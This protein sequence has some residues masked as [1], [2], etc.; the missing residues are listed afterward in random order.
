MIQ[1]ELRHYRMV[2]AVHHEGNL[3][4][5]ARKLWLTQ[6]ALSHQLKE[7]EEGLGLPVFL[8][9]KNTMILTAAGKILFGTAHKILTE[10]NEFKITFDN[11]RNGIKGRLRIGLGTK[12]AGYWLPSIFSSRSSL[13]PEL[14]MD[15]SDHSGQGAR[16]TLMAGK[17]DVLILELPSG[18]PK[19]KDL[20]YTKIGNS[21]KV[22]LMSGHSLMPQ[23]VQKLLTLDPDFQYSQL[24][25]ALV[26][27]KLVSPSALN[28][29]G[30]L[31]LFLKLVK[32]G[33]AIGILDAHLAGDL[34]TDGKFRTFPVNLPEARSSWYLVSLKEFEKIEPNRQFL[35]QF[36][37]Y[38]KYK[39][40]IPLIQSL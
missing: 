5:A 23:T 6:S 35:S 18:T 31:E 10:E 21:K 12:L 20:E 19:E 15:I 32:N 29:V 39:R 37:S 30:Q 27:R 34:G 38:L 36:R 28:S 24:F 14:P 33:F 22:F 26:A 16:E 25:Q 1:I 7:L 2:V 3:T 13:S 17:V 8:R 9:H 11:F 40:S 4:R